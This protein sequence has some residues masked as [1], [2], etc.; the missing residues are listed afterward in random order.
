MV[1]ADELLGPD[2]V[3]AGDVVVAMALVRA[4][5]Q[6]LLARPARAASTRAG[7][8]LDRHVPELGRTLGEELLEPT[9]IYALDC[10]ALARDAAA[11][12]HAFAH[13]TGGGLAAN[14]ARV[15]PAGWRRVVDRATWTPGADLRPGRARSAA[16][17]QAELERTLNLGV[18]MVAVVAPEPAPTARWRC[19]PSAAC[20]AWVCGTVTSAPDAGSPAAVAARGRLPR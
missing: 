7:W 20:T 14:L 3:R 8:T 12:V 4:A 13:V 17:P 18:G 9:R 19:W 6:R 15:L 11:E 2:R 10:L 1:E 16:W 5:L